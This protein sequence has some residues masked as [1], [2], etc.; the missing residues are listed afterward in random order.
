MPS[1]RFY[2]TKTS[3]MW[4]V[5]STRSELQALLQKCAV[6]SSLMC[7]NCR[8]SR[9]ASHAMLLLLTQNLAFSVWQPPQTPE[10]L[11][12]VKRFYFSS[13]GPRSFLD[14]QWISSHMLIC[15]Q[16]HIGKKSSMT[17]LKSCALSRTSCT[18]TSLQHVKNYLVSPK[19]HL[20]HPHYYTCRNYPLPSATIETELHTPCSYTSSQSVAVSLAKEQRTSPPSLAFTETEV[21]S[22]I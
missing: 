15:V 20:A 18:S 9:P 4:D 8:C 19:G 5:T 22:F 14:L 3:Q 12:L 13:Y 21:F 17:W 11:F 2:T 1:Y 7:I 16:D 6:D 10:F